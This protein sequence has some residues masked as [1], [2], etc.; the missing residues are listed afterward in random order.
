MQNSVGF[1]ALDP[2]IMPAAVSGPAAWAGGSLGS[3]YAGRHWGDHPFSRSLAAGAALLAEGK[4]ASS[5][6]KPI[7][8]GASPS[9]GAVICAGSWLRRPGWPSSIIRDFQTQCE[10]LAARLGNEISAGGHCAKIARRH[11]ACPQPL[12]SRLPCTRRGAHPHM[13][14]RDESDGNHSRQE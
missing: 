2:W 6:G 3:A 13:A 11:L 1:R 5:L 12:V 7:V 14:A 10:R 8:G 9:R 4:V